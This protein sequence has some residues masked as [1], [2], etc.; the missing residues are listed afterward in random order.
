MKEEPERFYLAEG[1]GFLTRQEY[2]E[3]L[4]IP[5]DY[6]PKISS[7]SRYGHLVSSN[8]LYVIMTING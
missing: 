8:P 3:K 5:A 1:N 2:K 6:Q 7:S 4:N